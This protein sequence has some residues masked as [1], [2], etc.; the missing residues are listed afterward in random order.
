MTR[1]QVTND[2]WLDKGMGLTKTEDFDTIWGIHPVERGVI[3]MYG[4]PVEVPRWTQAY[5]ISYRFSGK[6]HIAD[7]IPD[8]IKPYHNWANSLGYGEFNQILVNWYEGGKDSVAAHRDLSLIPGSP[9]ITYAMGST[10]SLRVRQVGI[11]GFR[12]HPMPNG[13][14]LVMGGA[15]Q[16]EMTHEIPK[17]AEKK[18]IGK[19]ISIT[20][21][22]FKV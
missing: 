5:G 22:Q 20:F 9:V 1:T 4:K 17:I 21:R 11:K 15:F 12:D 3:F 14:Y 6:N 16:E 2:S 8:I 19:R 18:G 10:R 13:S 7:P